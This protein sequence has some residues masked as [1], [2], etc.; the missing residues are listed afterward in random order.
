MGIVIS[1]LCQ[2]ANSIVKRWQDFSKK[3]LIGIF[4]NLKEKRFLPSEW[5]NYIQKHPSKYSVYDRHC[6]KCE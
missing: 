2:T 5:K 1:T 4:F 6:L 3:R